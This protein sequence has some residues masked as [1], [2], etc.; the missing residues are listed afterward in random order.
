MKYLITTLVIIC[1]L[2]ASS[3]VK[4][5][6]NQYGG[7]WKRLEVKVGFRLPMNDSSTRDFNSAAF[8]SAQ[9]YYDPTDSTIKYY[10]GFQ[11][12][13]LSPGISTNIYN[14][15]G[16]LTGNRTLTG[17]NNTYSLNFDSLSS[18][19]AGRNGVSRFS[20]NSTTSS[21]ISQ[22][23]N[24]AFTANPSNAIINYIGNAIRVFADSSTST[25]LIAYETNINGSL[26]T[27]A[28][29]SKSYVDSLVAAG[30]A[31]PSIDDVLAV[32]DTA[33]GKKFIMLDATDSLWLN[34]RPNTNFMSL[35]NLQ[36]IGGTQIGI[37]DDAR[38]LTFQAQ[39]GAQLNLG[40][41]GGTTLLGQTNDFTN[42]FLYI[43]DTGNPNDTLATLADV[44]AGGGG[45][46]VTSVS[47]GFGTNFSTITT[48]GSVVVDT[49][50]GGVTSWVRTKFILDSLQAAGWG[51]NISNNN[52]T[53]TASHTYNLGGYTQTIS[54]GTWLQDS[55]KFN[56]LPIFGTPDSLIAY[57]NS[58]TLGQN[59]SASDSA[60]IIRYGALL[61][62]IVDN[63]AVSGR[64][65]WRAT[66]EASAAENPGHTKMASV[67]AGFN[68]ARRGGLAR[69]TLNK[70]I[71]GHKAIFI[72][73]FLK[74]WVAAG[75]GAN[76]TRTGTW[77]TT[78]ASSTIGG[79]SVEL[80][81]YTN[82]I[83]DS[84][85]FTATGTNIVFSP[86]YGDGTTNVY[87]NSVEV[88]LDNVLQGT[89][90]FNQGT[91]AISDG[92]DANTY[93]P[94]GFIFS[95]LVYGSHKVKLINKDNHSMVIDYFGQLS[96]PN[97]SYPLLIFHSPKM[98][99]T[100]YAT[101]PAN[102]SDAIIDT[103]NAKI[104]S[105]V[106]TFPSLYPV[107]VA[108]T[109]SYYTNTTASGDLDVADHIHPT[110]QG[111]RKIYNA[112]VAAFGSLSTL[113]GT[114][115]TVFW[116]G[117]RPW[118][119]DSTATKRQIALIGDNNGVTTIGAFG[120]SPNSSGGTIS[121]AALTLQPAS[122]TQPGGVST[123]YQ[124]FAGDKA[125]SG[126]FQIQ[127]A[128]SAPTGA[129][130]EGEYTGGVAYWRAY[131][132]AG[133]Y[134]TANIDAN[135][136]NFRVGTTTKL[137]VAASSG[138]TATARISQGQGADVS[139]A[140]NLALGT[141]GNTFEITG[142]TQVNLL[143]NL[144]W[145][146]GAVVHLI[147]TSNPT[148]KNGQTTSTTNITILLAGAADFVAS[149]D[150]VLTLMLCEIGGTQ[151]W[152]EVSRSVN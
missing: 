63:K 17:L 99:A 34:F 23:T 142:T 96:E 72:N 88:Y 151:A 28:L 126:G 90:S 67:M 117:G 109:N 122:A 129:G 51:K 33:F 150:D 75:N 35:G 44:R 77:T 81:A 108:H 133:S 95:G 93:Q 8:D 12:L 134:L 140:N 47:S 125:I 14:S 124:T 42:D 131:N 112:A 1:C 79:K 6:Y 49:T 46:G 152:R 102:A 4:Q 15:S 120:S 83:N 118:I 97:N 139:S 27:N 76:V 41:G 39:Y 89:Y 25:K 147:F 116:S 38:Q 94:G 37:D 115:G 141:D 53:S 19:R 86:I 70:I 30:G 114:P 29:T 107:Y 111:H 71:N 59:T 91:D 58:I 22:N 60:Y 121:G 74:F 104:D 26:T 146:N 110:N 61:G 137:S 18:F 50:S 78:F 48:T 62:L 16:I 138:M 128:L 148:V 2:S 24:A 52:L 55:T 10:T 21:M 105:L 65:I 82:T 145:Q 64:G 92:A 40:L 149:A 119:F 11:W 31:A 7:T 73:H 36:R 20:F 127:G 101:S 87:S 80:G 123:A 132:R 32:G 144:N 9:V 84:I 43:P 13:A 135:I 56:A 3:Q 130:W 100:G 85:T 69:K 106:A 54:N 136:L 5:L 98:D 113:T 103:V 143:S 66:S 45:G 68:D 57:G